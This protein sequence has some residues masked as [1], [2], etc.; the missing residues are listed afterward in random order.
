LEET[1]LDRLSQTPADVARAIVHAGLRVW[2]RSCVPTNLLKRAANFIDRESSLSAICSHVIEHIHLLQAEAGFDI[3]HSE[4]RWRR[5]IFVSI[6]E[7]DGS[8]GA[9]RLAEGI[10]HEAMHLNL[11]NVEVDEPL[12]CEFVGKMR[13]PWK[14]ESR[15]YQGVLHGLFVFACLG[16]YFKN[17]LRVIEKDDA[18]KN[19]CAR[20]VADIAAEIG[21]IDVDELCRGLTRRGALL[22][23]SW[24]KVG[25]IASY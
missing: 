1:I 2:D 16:R 19:H 4:P 23:M 10:I 25:R 7:R 17:I 24:Q 5:R 14:V 6:P 9:M 21:S 18:L 11:T 12:V 20:R 3:S 15:P 8:V 22:A 13:S